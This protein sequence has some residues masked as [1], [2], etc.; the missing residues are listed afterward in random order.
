MA[1]LAAHLLVGSIGTLGIVTEIRLK[2]I[3][4]RP[5]KGT[6]VA[7]FRDYDE[8]ADAALRLKSLDPAALEFTDAS[9]AGRANGQI[10]NLADPSIVGTSRPRRDE[11]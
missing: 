8:F 10:L 6:F 4:Q 3:E 11:N 7:H 2:L 9:C 1:E 5:S